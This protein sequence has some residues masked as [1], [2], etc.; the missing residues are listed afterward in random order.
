ME[1]FKRVGTDPSGLRLVAALHGQRSLKRKK[2]KRKRKRHLLELSPSSFFFKT[3]D[4]PAGRDVRGCQGVIDEGNE[5]V[6][7]VGK[8]EAREA[9]TKNK[10]SKKEIAGKVLGKFLERTR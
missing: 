1:N 6:I 7:A 8:C 2:K 5:K 3:F 10:K 9:K 4:G